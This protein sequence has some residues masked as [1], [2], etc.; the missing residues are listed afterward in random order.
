M[1]NSELRRELKTMGVAFWMVAEQLGV[2]EATIQRMFRKELTE[3]QRKKIMAA[4]KKAAAT[5][6]GRGAV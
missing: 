4:A 1:A 3:Q 5:I 2:C 6:S